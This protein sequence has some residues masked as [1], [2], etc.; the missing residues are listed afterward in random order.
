MATW[1]WALCFTEQEAWST[2]T[3]S[4][5]IWTSAYECVRVCVR[6]RK[7]ERMVFN[8][9][10]VYFSIKCN[11][12]IEQSNNE[13]K[14]E[15]KQNAS[16]KSFIHKRRKTAAAT[17]TATAMRWSWLTSHIGFHSLISTISVYRCVCIVC[18]LNN[19]AKWDNQKSPLDF[20]INFFF[21]NSFLMLYI[22]HC[23]N[24]IELEL[25]CFDGASMY[26]QCFCLRIPFHI[27]LFLLFICSIFF[28]SICTMCTHLAIAISRNSH[29]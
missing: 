11:S 7:R 29:R 24:L 6:V 4:K 2:S 10:G 8:L 20:N 15:R 21:P 17:T 13:G 14:N 25:E 9:V 18:E 26:A 12:K 1:C 5:T 27:A 22:G 23:D 19:T 16:R 28:F 3:H